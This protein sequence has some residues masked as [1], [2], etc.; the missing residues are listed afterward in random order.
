[1]SL[2]LGILA[3]VKPSIVSKMWSLPNSLI[4]QFCFAIQ[5]F[6]KSYQSRNLIQTLAQRLQSRNIHVLTYLNCM[7]A[8]LS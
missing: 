8:Y 5:T 3:E 4:M 1:M 6:H 7:I 2:K